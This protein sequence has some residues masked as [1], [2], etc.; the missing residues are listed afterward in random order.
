[1]KKITTK[2]V[3]KCFVSL[4]FC[5]TIST[6]AK[7]PEL[8]GPEKEK[9]LK[10]S[11]DKILQNIDPEAL[12]LKRKSAYALCKEQ[13]YQD[14][15]PIFEELVKSQQH[16]FEERLKR[17]P[18]YI[19]RIKRDNNFFED[20]RGLACLSNQTNDI[21]MLNT[22]YNL[23]YQYEQADIN[24]NRNYINFIYSAFFTVK[25]VEETLKN[26]NYSEENIIFACQKVIEGSGALDYEMC[27]AS[28]IL[29]KINNKEN[30]EQ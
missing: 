24:D 1:M 25:D 22:A 29:F 9:G 21:L 15:K 8:E 2:M 19:S 23:I 3:I 27:M 10:V 7:P 18:K 17:N 4:F 12:K 26:N 28:S 16:I 20:C 6:H 5:F 11:P 13:K 14:A 30:V